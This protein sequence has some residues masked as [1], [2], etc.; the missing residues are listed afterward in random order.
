MLF[1]F[2]GFKKRLYIEQITNSGHEKYVFP[3]PHPRTCLER[4]MKRVRE[5]GREERKEAVREGRGEAN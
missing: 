1:F 4:R 2:C 3:N 5:R